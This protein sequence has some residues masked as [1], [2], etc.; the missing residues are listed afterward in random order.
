MRLQLPHFTLA[1]RR[2]TR[3]RRTFRL[4]VVIV[5]FVLCGRA[6]P[7]SPTVRVYLPPAKTT[8]SHSSQLVQEIKTPMYALTSEEDKVLRPVRL[9][10]R[11]VHSVLR[12]LGAR[13]DLQTAHALL[14]RRDLAR[15]RLVVRVERTSASNSAVSPVNTPCSHSALSAR[16]SSVRSWCRGILAARARSSAARRSP[17]SRLRCVSS[18]CCR[19]ADRP[20]GREQRRQLRSSQ[21]AVHMGKAPKAK[22]EAAGAEKGWDGSNFQTRGG[23]RRSC[24]QTLRAH[25]IT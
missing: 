16:S 6:R 7:I 15:L 14:Q 11:A 8:I 5:A 19:C 20:I 1:L 12:H 10:R 2:L 17:S 13:R 25:V 9:V 4:V 24:V 21:H 3:R 23:S 18:S 22:T